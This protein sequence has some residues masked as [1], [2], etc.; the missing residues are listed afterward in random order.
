M[1][2]LELNDFIDFRNEDVTRELVGEVCEV[3]VANGYELDESAEEMYEFLV[4]G[5]YDGIC[6]HQ[7]DE[8]AYTVY[9]ADGCKFNRALSVSE[10]LGGNS[11]EEASEI[12]Q[13][14]LLHTIVVL[15]SA[16]GNTGSEK[17]TKIVEDLSEKAA[18][19]FLG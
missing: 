5:D 16:S 2:K 7:E 9:Y 4:D 3:I 12:D 6:I 19:K 11:K 18:K 15:S 17:I 10:V 14:E 1:F 8:D 13:D